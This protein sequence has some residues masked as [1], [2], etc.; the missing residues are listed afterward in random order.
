MRKIVLLILGITMFLCFDFMA[1][2]ILS[3][4]I[5][6]GDELEENEVEHD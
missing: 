1:W 4:S 3:K 5:D 6:N 2:A